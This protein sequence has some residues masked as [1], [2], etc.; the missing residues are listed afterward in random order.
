MDAIERFGQRLHEAL[1]KGLQSKKLSG[2][3]GNFAIIVHETKTWTVITKGAKPRIIEAMTDDEMDFIM[4]VTREVFEKMYPLDGQ[5]SD[6]DVDQV[7]A[8][9]RIAMHGDMAVFV[10]FIALNAAQDMLSL[11]SSGAA[12]VKTTAKPTAKK[13]ARA[14]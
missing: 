6:L 11:R 10:K 4:I 13:R 1:A 12:S 7:I 9:N 8:S 14:V 3:G 5:P 2:V